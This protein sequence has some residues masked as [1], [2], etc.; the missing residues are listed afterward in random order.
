MRNPESL[1]LFTIGHSNHQLEKLL[2]LLRQQ[3]IEVVVDVR[4]QPYSKYAAHFN[5]DPLREAVNLEGMQFLFLG[6]SLGGR[7]EGDDFYDAE[8]H[9]RYDRVAQSPAFLE[10][11]ASL[12]QVLRHNRAAILCSEEDPAVCHRHLLVGRV[13]AERGI[14]MLHIRGDGR[15][16]SDE[17]LKKNAAG[18]I[19]LMLFGDVEEKPWRSLRPIRPG[20]AAAPAEE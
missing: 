18:E 17:D 15:L 13:L 9:V 7:P 5:L 3:E 19:Q 6:H 1:R 14:A 4:S 8:G 11:I 16:Q 12:D 20:S 10:G 2:D